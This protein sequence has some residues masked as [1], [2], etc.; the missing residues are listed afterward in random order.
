MPKLVVTVALTL[1]AAGI[2]RNCVAACRRPKRRV[3]SAGLERNEGFA[4]GAPVSGGE[5]HRSRAVEIEFN[6][7]AGLK[8]KIAAGEAFDATI[9]TVEAIDELIVHGILAAA[10]RTEV[11]RSQLGIGI[12]SGAPKPDIRTPEALKQSLLAA[13]SITFPQ[14]GASRGYLEEMFERLGVAAQLKPKIIL[15][16]GSGPATES[17]ARGD[18]AM[19]LTLFSEIVTISGVEVLGPLPGA[20]RFDQVRGGS[21]HEVAERSCRKGP[22]RISHEPGSSARAESERHRAEVTSRSI[23]TLAS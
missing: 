6:S 8:K 16:P 2:D 10:S 13:K 4:R 1:A 15:A 3:S 18:A 12:R 21:E 20:Y 22:D 23:G 17:V 14:D 19:V 11:G 9:I 5:G 7:T